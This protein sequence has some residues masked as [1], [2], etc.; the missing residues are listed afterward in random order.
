[1]ST[2]VGDTTA[3]ATAISVAETTRQA[4]QNKERGREIVG[5]AARA[6]ERI[7]ATSDDIGKITSVIDNI[8][9]QTNLLA[10]NAGVAAARAGDAGRSFAVVAA[11]VRNLALR[12]SDAAQEIRD[13]I[14]KSESEVGE[15]VK[16]VTQT[17]SALME[18]G[19]AVSRAAELVDRIAHH[20]EAQSDS[21]RAISVTMG[22]L[23]AVT[24]QNA[25]LF[26]ETRKPC[27]ALTRSAETAEHLT[28]Q[29]TLDRKLLATGH[30]R[31]A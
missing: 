11:E 28:S 9:F 7:E 5:E 1:L 23:D 27:S 21:V 2:D 6:I 17:V 10:L 16:S 14:G 15:G 8:A 4:Q 12:S 24:K 25:A 20:A 29:F 22:K 13:L 18:V 3:T 31:A 30:G 19:E 26:S